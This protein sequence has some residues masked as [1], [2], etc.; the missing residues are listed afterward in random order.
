M[1]TIRTIG[2]SMVVLT[3][4]RLTTS[5]IVNSNNIKLT[6]KKI[7]KQTKLMFHS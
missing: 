1:L 7:E 4:N 2:A 3:Y 5:F 6:Q